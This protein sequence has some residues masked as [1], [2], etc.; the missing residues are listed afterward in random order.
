MTDLEKIRNWIIT[1]PKIDAALDLRVDYY[2]D[3]PENSSLAPAGMTELSRKND[4]MGNCIVENQYNFALYFVFPK[5]P[6]DDIG[7]TEN[8]E[9]LLDFQDWVQ[10]QSVIRKTPIF[11]DEPNT[12]SIKAQSGE[13]IDADPNGIGLYMVLLTIN[14]KKI[15]EVNK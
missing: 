13:I 8:A 4:I 6:E 7:A 15:Y 10:E 9:W 11:G 1:Y 3:K 5:S 12:E 2:A 14:F